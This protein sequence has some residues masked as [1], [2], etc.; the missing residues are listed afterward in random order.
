MI[1]WLNGTLR[2]K[3][4]PALLL[5]VNGVGYEIESP[6]STFADLP[7]AGNTVSLFMHFVV[8]EDAQQLYGFSKRRERDLFRQLIKVNGVGAKLALTIMSGMDAD[9]LARCVLDGDTASLSKLPGI[10]RK[11]A[12]RLVVELR[13][14]LDVEPGASTGG[15]AGIPA[16]SRPAKPPDEAISALIALGLKPPEASRRVA[17]I[18]A[19]HL[20]SEEIVRLALQSMVRP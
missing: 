3:S 1:G 15:L 11:T 14:R 10:G 2:E 13:D 6:M 4:P 20:S 12:E 16:A 9:G 7:D 5:D 8:R 19:E 18:E 17:A